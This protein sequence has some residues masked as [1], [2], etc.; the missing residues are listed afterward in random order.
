MAAGPR[1]ER[2]VGELLLLSELTGHHTRLP[3]DAL[4]DGMR[5]DV[6]RADLRKAR[7]FV[8]DAKSTEWPEGVPAARVGRYGRWVT[9]LARAGG[10]GVLV[11][12]TDDQDCADAWAV[13]L[14]SIAGA[15]FDVVRARVQPGLHV[16]SVLCRPAVRPRLS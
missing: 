11:I 2:L 10:C 4:P 12:A 14:R 6:L 5:P 13:E 1:H 7:L 3:G 16:S 8:G 15:S 9:A